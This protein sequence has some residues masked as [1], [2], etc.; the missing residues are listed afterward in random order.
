MT[1]TIPVPRAW[2]ERLLQLNKNASEAISGTSL[3]KFHYEATTLI[4][5][6]SSTETL[7]TNGEKGKE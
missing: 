4:G 1:D 7:L 2:L 3:A 6:I 5:Y